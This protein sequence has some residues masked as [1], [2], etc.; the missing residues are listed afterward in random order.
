MIEKEKNKKKKKKEREKKGRRAPNCSALRVLFA[1]DCC[2]MWPNIQSP[3]GKMFQFLSASCFSRLSF[4]DLALVFLLLLLLS[5]LPFSFS[6][7]VSPTHLRRVATADKH[8]ISCHSSSPASHPERDSLSCQFPV[9]CLLPPNSNS[10]KTI[11]IGGLINLKQS[12]RHLYL[13]GKA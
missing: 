11:I 5:L 1:P 10:S 7:A 12:A 4:Q 13:N 8:F 3:S 6:C 9:S 2:R